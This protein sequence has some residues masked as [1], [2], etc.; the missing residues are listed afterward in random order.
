MKKHL[1]PLVQ[2]AS[3]ITAQRLVSAEPLLVAPALVGARLASP[4]R[5]AAAM[6]LDLLAI[7]LLTGVGGLWLLVAI[8]VVLLQL[9]SRRGGVPRTRAMWLGWA[10]AALVLWLAASALHERWQGRGDE[11]VAATQ[12]A[13]ARD[14][15][16]EDDTAAE[17]AKAL[18]R[19]AANPENPAS[20]P[21]AALAVRIGELEAALAKANRRPKGV[22][23][24]LSGWLDEIGAGIGWGIVYFSL[25]PA[26][27]QGQTL[28]KKLLRLRIV[29]L[30]GQ[31]ITVLRSLKRY[32][33]YAAGLATGGIGLAQLLWDPNRQGLHDKAAHTVVIDERAAHDSIRPS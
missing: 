13:A 17:Q 20:A 19:P 5:R 31:P 28:G 3:S 6:A 7:A 21:E 22:R 16:D 23:A 33:G 32:G 27:W 14:A 25:L 4:G 29:E 2:R 15:D 18:G 12:A 10:A 24:Y 9:A 8:A 1:V 11:S 26:W 30:A